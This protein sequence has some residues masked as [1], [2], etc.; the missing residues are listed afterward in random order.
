MKKIIIFL[1]GISILAGWYFW[2]QA[3]DQTTSP[4]KKLVNSTSTTEPKHVPITNPQTITIPK[5]GVSAPVES[6]GMDAQGNMDVPKNADNVAWYNLGYKVGDN[7][8]AVIAGHYDKVT[9]APAVF[10]RLSSLQPG[11]EI[12]VT[13]EENITFTYRVTDMQSYHHQ[14]VPLEKIFN[15]PGK[16]TLNLITCEGI[17]DKTTNLYSKRLI[18]YSELVET[19]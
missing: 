19:N 9:G 13:S 18:V 15:T 12:S 17:F 6:V 1:A 4:L 14:D 2:G 7:G 11:D 3:P 10:Y 8:S 5:L 16:P